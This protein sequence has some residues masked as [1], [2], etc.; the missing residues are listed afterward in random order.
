MKTI[1]G[2]S[3]ILVL[4]LIVAP[5]YADDF[6]D[7]INAYNRKDFKT[8]F[9]K[10]KPFA[11]Q[12]N[13]VAQS[14]LGVMY[15]K[16][17]DVTQD[18]EKAVK[19]YRLSAEQGNA[20]GQYNLGLIYAKGEGVTQDY[21]QAHLWFT[22]SGDQGIEDAQKARDKVEKLMTSEQIARS[23][24]LSKDWRPHRLEGSGSGFFVTKEGHIL[25]NFHVVKGCLNVKSISHGTL[26]VI[27]QDSN[28]DLALLKTSKAKKGV[29]VFSNSEAILGAKVLTAGYPLR[30]VLASL[31]NITD[32]II[33]SLAGVKNDPRYIQVTAP[34]QP[35]N[36]GGP[37]IDQS[38][39]VLGII[40]MKLN[41]IRIAKFTG[42]I[43]QNVNFALRSDFAKK[44]MDANKVKYSTAISNIKQEITEIA[45]SADKFTL[46]IECWK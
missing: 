20:I 9:E 7:G 16:G 46:S 22:L 15:L 39:N 14:T 23:Q 3:L 28:Y 13:A 36:S 26:K 10:L 37:L 31:I 1:I 11:K 27:A 32:G 41:A 12:G 4:S 43:P 2:C 38:G 6:Q 25:T 29:A 30:V 5:V 8:A 18:Y 42:D 17:E 35:G 40:T 44:F 34:V 33:S 19:W 21:V 45:K 24:E